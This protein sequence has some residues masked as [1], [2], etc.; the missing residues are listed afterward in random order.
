M[1]TTVQ[2]QKQQSRMISHSITVA[3][4]TVAQTTTSTNPA[5]E[6]ITWTK[7]ELEKYIATLEKVGNSEHIA[8]ILENINNL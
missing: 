6:M 5:K 8:D 4:E 3:Q 1:N 2:T 7:T